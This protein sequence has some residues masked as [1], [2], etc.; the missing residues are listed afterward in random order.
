MKEKPVKASRAA[1][2]RPANLTNP[3]TCRTAEP[4][5][6][7]YAILDLEAL[8]AHG[9]EPRPVFRAWLD[10]GVRLIQLRT[11]T[12]ASGPLVDLAR[13]LGADARRAGAAFILNDRA[14]LARMSGAAGVHVGQTDLPPADARKIL[15]PRRSRGALD[16]RRGRARRRDA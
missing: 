16:A 9:L 10:A 6:R 3:R 4:F 2:G 8:A 5:P 14:D 12:L 1:A 15:G 13:E 11:K 7:L